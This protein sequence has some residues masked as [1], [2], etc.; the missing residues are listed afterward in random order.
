[1][2]SHLSFQDSYGVV[3]IN[4]TIPISRIWY[5]SAVVL[6]TIALL[7]SNSLFMLAAILLGTVALR[8]VRGVLTDDAPTISANSTNKHLAV[9]QGATHRHG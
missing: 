6:V 9:Q 5:G 7:I 2:T 4:V 8:R 3:A 1:M